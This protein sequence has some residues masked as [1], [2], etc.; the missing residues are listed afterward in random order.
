MVAKLPP[1]GSGVWKH[2]PTAGNGGVEIQSVL[3]PGLA[4]GSAD[5]AAVAA[6][7]SGSASAEWN[8]IP[9]DHFNQH[10]DMPSQETSRKNFPAPNQN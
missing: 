10:D 6:A 3:K 7:P 9:A 4:I 2:V 1:A 5:G 8:V